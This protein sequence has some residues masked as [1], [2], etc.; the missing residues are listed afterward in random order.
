MATR[1]AQSQSSRLVWA[2]IKTQQYKARLCK[3]SLWLRFWDESRE[4]HEP[5]RKAWQLVHARLKNAKKRRDLVRGPMSGVVASLMDLS[6]LPCEPEKFK[7]VAGDWWEFTGGTFTNILDEIHHCTTEPAHT[8][9]EVVWSTERTHV[10]FA[11]STLGPSGMG[12]MAKWDSWKAAA[13]GGLWPVARLKDAD[14]RYDGLCQGCLAEGSETKETMLHR[15]WQCPCNP[16]D[17]IFNAT[18]KWCK[19]AEQQQNEYACFWM[20]GLVPED[21][22]LADRNGRPDSTLDM[23]GDMTREAS[24]R[25]TCGL[26]KWTIGSGRRADI[27]GKQTVPRAE[28]VAMVI[29]AENISDAGT[30]ELKVDAQYLL[31]IHG[32]PNSTN[33]RIKRRLVYTLLQCSGKEASLQLACR[34]RLEEPQQAGQW[35]RYDL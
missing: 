30:Y 1:S 21:W 15:V 34:R 20:R 11:N 6:G 23:V 14:E 32:T 29:F 4:M 17:G 8:R 12:C 2:S 35:M 33:A 31:H 22:I 24:T 18:E 10:A 25:Q 7:S 19:K 27:P 28:L 9:M 5:V 13:A 26:G 16:T 3:F